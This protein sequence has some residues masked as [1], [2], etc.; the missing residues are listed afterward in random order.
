MPDDAYSGYQHNA[1]GAIIVVDITQ[2]SYPLEWKD[3]FL[4]DSTGALVTRD[5]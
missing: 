1:T 4:V 3:G 5:G 2:A